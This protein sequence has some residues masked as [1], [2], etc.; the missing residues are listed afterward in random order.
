MKAKRISMLLRRAHFWLC[1]MPGQI[2][3]LEEQLSG[4]PIRIERAAQP[5]SKFGPYDYILIDA[6][7]RDEPIDLVVAS[8]LDILEEHSEVVRQIAPMLG[9]VRISATS[10]DVKYS[11]EIDSSTF[12]RLARLN[13]R[14]TFAFEHALPDAVAPPD[15]A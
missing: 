11:E 5:Q 8:L 4:A 9:G 15:V 10:S 1:C 3:R 2:G 13:L 6:P 12:D 7:L 14:A